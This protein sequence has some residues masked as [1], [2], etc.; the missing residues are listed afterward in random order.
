[1]SDL[2][3]VWQGL[4]AE[5]ENS[6]SAAS[7]FSL[8][9]LES[10]PTARVFAA[11]GGDPCGPALL[12]DLPRGLRKTL[13]SHLSSRAFSVQAA[14]FPGLQPDRVGVMTRL[15]DNAYSDLFELL[16]SEI[17]VAVCS[18][19]S[20]KAA[21]V[22]LERVI[23]RWRHF[24]E[25]RS[26]PLTPERV[27]GLIGEAVILM[28]LMDRIGAMTALTQWTGPQDALRDF[29]LDDVSVEVKAYQTQTGKSVRISD[30]G[31][32]EAAPGRSVYLAVVGLAV[33]MSSG[34]TLAE[35]VKMLSEVASAHPGG[36]ELLEDRLAQ[37]GYLNAHAAMYPDAYVID[38]PALYSVND[39]FPTIAASAVPPGVE[40]VR[41]S[42]QLSAIRQFAVDGD[43][44]IGRTCALEEGKA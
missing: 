6:D 4:S 11:W 41:F 24:V 42:I 29:E 26:A 18:K 25:R 21:V 43:D 44:V 32:L 27:R 20:G 7:Q 1:M 33:N 39:G 37:Y 16:C 9:L 17:T 34:R 5:H 3:I 30:P 23:D 22:A 8:K 38:K 35:I 36:V 12:V 2:E 19:R 28:R 13:R 15:S 40:D 31:Q 10:T 14:E